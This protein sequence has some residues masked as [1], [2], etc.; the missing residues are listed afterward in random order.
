MHHFSWLG[1]LFK[2]EEH[3]I[4]IYHAAFT[5]ILLFALGI[6][7]YLKLRKID[8]AVVPGSKLGVVSVFEVVCESI[9]GLM[10]SIIGPEAKKY[11]PMI[12][13][14]FI[15]I[16]I[17]NLMG[18]IPGFLPPT[19]NINTTLSCGLIVFVY[20]NY[21]GIREQGVIN[22]FKHFAGPVIFLAPLMLVIELIG[23]A[24]RPVSLALRLFGN[25]TGDHMVLGIFSDLVPIGV[26]VLFLALGIFVSFIQAFVFSL[27]S[28]I[29]VS[30]ALPHEEHH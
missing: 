24:V 22:Y 8:T 4:H 15:Y 13:T 7:V 16:F 28:T 25:I 3:Y 9:L 10:E 14:L 29:Y 21:V 2:A 19:D 26:P 1:Y 5:A 11:F 20:F 17:N 27:L 6:I 18:V 12:G 30:L 23:I